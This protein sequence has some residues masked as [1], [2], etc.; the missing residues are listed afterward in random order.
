MTIY[1]DGEQTRDYVYV[2]DVVR[3]NVAALAATVSGAFNIG[4]GVETNVN[5]LYQ[6]LAATRASAERPI[7]V[8]RGRASSGARL[9]R[10]Q[11][12]ASELGWQPASGIVGG[13]G[14]DAAF[15]S[16]TRGTLAQ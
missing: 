11:R 2:G 1:G 12:A 6:T 13:S 16:R 14:A 10:R 9:S 15:L 3:A 4:T 7:T 8:R 5:Q